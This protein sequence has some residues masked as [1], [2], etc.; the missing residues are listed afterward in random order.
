M[1]ALVVVRNHKGSQDA[2]K[3]QILGQDGAS[4]GKLLPQ[5][6]IFPNNLFGVFANIFMI[7]YIQ[8]RD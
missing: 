5:P 2:D 1:V 3:F 8:I 7:K 4:N 6:L